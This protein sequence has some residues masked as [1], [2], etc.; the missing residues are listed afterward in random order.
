MR[1]SGLLVAVFALAFASGPGVSGLHSQSAAKI[2]RIHPFTG[3]GLT[4]SEAVAAQNLVTSY[5][6]EYRNFRVI[7][8]DGQELAL[9]EAETAI[10][11]GIPRDISPL[12][13]DYILSANALSA[14]GLIV[15]T[16]DLTKVTTGEKRSVSKPASS[17]NDL[18]LS[19]RG[20]TNS[21]F[22]ANQAG[23]PANQA[24][25]ESTAQGQAPVVAQAASAM[26]AAPKISMIVGSWKGDKGVDRV[27]IFRDGRGIVIL[28]SGV[29][30]RVKASVSDSSII[31]AQDQAN[32][33]DFYRSS[34]LDL[35]AA[36]AISA[37]ARPWRWIFSLSESQK[38]L[39]GVKESV[40]VKLDNAGAVTV[41]NNYVREASWSRLFR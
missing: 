2:L 13:A 18:I 5:V 31:I 27:S 6:V 23:A 24:A 10:Q 41:D 3:D 9:K 33:P 8:A 22:E 20:L 39:I 37:Q 29:S 17:V 38:D 19:L 36:R 28:S 16:M 14:G 26:V 40:F 12:A 4:A 34:G 32:S 21:L 35:K 15:F 7:D 11:L 25:A 1:S 30:M